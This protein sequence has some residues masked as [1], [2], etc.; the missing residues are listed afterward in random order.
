LKVFLP[1][2]RSSL[3]F[4]KVPTCPELVEGLPS[5]SKAFLS[6]EGP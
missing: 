2:G 1:W 6:F 3:R 4:A 5:L